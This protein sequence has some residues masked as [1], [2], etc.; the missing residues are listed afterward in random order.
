MV[1]ISERW[2]QSLVVGHLVVNNEWFEG[3]CDAG[4]VFDGEECIASSASRGAQE[5]MER[6]QVVV[7]AKLS[8]VAGLK[9]ALPMRR[10]F[11][12]LVEG[13]GEKRLQRQALEAEDGGRLSKV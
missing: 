10:E 12:R 1:A 3:C 8:V 6:E 5:A 2:A 4:D 7:A 9:R 11:T 13:R